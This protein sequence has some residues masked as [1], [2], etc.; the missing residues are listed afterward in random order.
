MDKEMQQRLILMQRRQHA[1][2][3]I[4]NIMALRECLHL[5]EEKLCLEKEPLSLAASAKKETLSRLEVQL[6]TLQC[7]YENLLIQI[8]VA[9]NIAPVLQALETLLQRLCALFSLKENVAFKLFYEHEIT[10]ERASMLL[11]QAIDNVAKDD[12]VGASLASAP[13][14]TSRK[15]L[16]GSKDKRTKDPKVEMR[17][18]SAKKGIEAE[19]TRVEYSLLAPRRIEKGETFL[20]DFYMYEKKYQGIVEEAFALGGDA[21]Q[22]KDSGVSLAEKG[23]EITAHLYSPSLPDIDD[24]D[25]FL[26]MGSYHVSQ[27]CGLIP[28]NY[29]SNTILLCVDILVYGLKVTTLKCVIN[30]DAKKQEQSFLRVDI[31]KAFF[32]YSS[33]DRDIVLT[34]KQGMEGLCPEVVC[35][36]DF[37]F[38]KGGQQWLEEVHHKIDE[39]DC[40]FLIWSENAYKSEWVK[41]EWTY[42]LGTKGLS[43]IHPLAIEAVDQKKC[44]VPKALESIH[45]G[46]VNALLRQKH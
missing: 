13:S 11:E 22:K 30:L 12:I 27:L 43:F 45:F 44:P 34:L 29:P 46:N 15:G 26:W 21:L 4:K 18:A 41:E 9:S 17:I 7:A 6:E 42:A 39:S 40:L 24:R 1:H 31:K 28:D 14:A 32:S 35:Y 16:F 19:K 3:A 37:L 10:L 5:R 20:L 25:T 8:D 33:K 23:S 38:L 2:A 36:V